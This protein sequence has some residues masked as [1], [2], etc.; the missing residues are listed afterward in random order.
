M[1][2]HLG[3]N[4]IYINGPPWPQKKE[5]RL[6]NDF[7]WTSKRISDAGLFNKSGTCWA[8]TENTKQ[9]TL[10]SLFLYC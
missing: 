6:E 10:R 1:G 4:H 2:T 8:L 5:S 3:A 9:M 7:K